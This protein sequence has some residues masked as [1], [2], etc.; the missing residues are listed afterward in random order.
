[1]SSDIVPLQISSSDEDR[2]NNLLYNSIYPSYRQSMAF[3]YA[4]E[5]WK[6]NVSTFVFVRD[7]IDIAG[8]HYSIKQT[9]YGL[10]KTAD[11]LSGFIFRERPTHGLLELLADHFLGFASKEGADYVRLF[12]WLPI[13]FAGQ[14]TDYKGMLKEVLTAKGFSTIMEGRHTYWIDLSK[15][16]DELLYQTRRQTRYDI[17]K[18]LRSGITTTK[19]TDLSNEIVDLFWDRYSLIADKKRFHKYPE[20]KFKHEISSLLKSRMAILF[21][22]NYND[23]I[24]NFSI[25]SNFGIASYLHGAIDPDFKK[26]PGCPSPGHMAQWQMLTEMKLKG[27]MYYDMGFCPGPTPFPEHPAYDIWKFKYGFGGEHVRFADNYG[28]SIQPLKGML[29]NVVKKLL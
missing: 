13:S 5:R 15:S 26:M 11:L 28:K 21:V 18:G 10:F 29:Y 20:T 14:E 2:W 7:G 22:Q 4:R 12:P 1:V 25:A 17:R 6:R 27:A 19:Y 8:V 24:V 3:E 16:E 9:R 23:H